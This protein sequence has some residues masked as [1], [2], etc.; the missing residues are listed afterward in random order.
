[1]LNTYVIIN[2]LYQKPIWGIVIIPILQ[3]GKLHKELSNLPEVSQLMIRSQDETQFPVTLMGNSQPALKF[4]PIFIH[5][6]CAGHSLCARQD[7]R[8]VREI[9]KPFT[10]S[11]GAQLLYNVIIL[12][13]V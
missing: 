6:M 12:M 9:L 3:T 2:H 5:Q 13:S 1:M 4:I 8:T 7:V 11:R 10:T